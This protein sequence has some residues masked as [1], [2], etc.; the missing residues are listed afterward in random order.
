MC[1]LGSASKPSTSRAASL[2]FQTVKG[3][4]CEDSESSG[5]DDDEV[6]T[7]EGCVANVRLSS[8]KFRTGKS[9]DRTGN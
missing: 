5:G 7:Y 9:S 3:S 1:Y 2:M 8:R 6:E 4:Y